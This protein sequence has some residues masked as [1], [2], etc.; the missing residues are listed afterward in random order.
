MSSTPAGNGHT[1]LNAGRRSELTAW[2]SGPA[3]QRLLEAETQA[4]GRFLPDLFGYYLIQVG[5]S[6]DVDLLASS[7]VMHRLVVSD[8]TPGCAMT[9][10]ACA[11][12]CPTQLPVANDSTDVVLLQHVLEYEANPHEALREAERILVPEGH[13]IIAGFNPYGLVGLWRLLRARRRGGPFRGEFFSQRRIRDWL[14]LL[15]FDLVAGE[16]FF[17][18]P[19]VGNDRLMRRLSWLERIGAKFWPFFAG[20]YVL[21][22]RKRVITVTPIRPH[23]RTKRRLAAVGLV[24]TAPRVTDVASRQV[25]RPAVHL[26]VFPG[27]LSAGPEMGEEGGGGL[28]PLSRS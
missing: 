9:D 27:G 24:G 25:G 11:C 22:A 13:V 21:V 17:Y 7:R 14:A 2:F 19:P 1:D 28:N 8:C 3:G 5:H 10:Y 26:K 20:C 12:G 4:I 16:R 23:W 18:R 6:A 15:G